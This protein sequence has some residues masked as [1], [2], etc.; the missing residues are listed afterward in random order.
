[1]TKKTAKILSVLTIIIMLCYVFMNFSEIFGTPVF[2]G[3]PIISTRLVITSKSATFCN[4]TLEPGWN[5]VSFP[6]LSDPLDID[7]MMS[8]LNNSYDSLR[9]YNPADSDD[10]WKSYNPDLPSW[11]RHDL[12][13][14]SRAR[15]YW[16][17]VEGNATEYYLNGNLSTP[18]LIDLED[19]WNLIGYPSRSI[20]KVNDTFG[21]LVPNFHY[22]HLY[23]ASETD[24][25]K[26]WTWNTTL[27]PSNQD[28]NY[29]LLYHGYW[30]YM[31]TT[32]TLVI[33]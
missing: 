14:I 8:P 16:I 6:C 11:V 27:Y 20:R 28:L 7:F 29:T 26:E 19:G 23:N 9:F 15:G 21:S 33:S 12:G 32:D 3:W 2:T 17:Y 5:L 25:W 24:K 22:V 4:M 10:P 31:S 18:T 1:M 30:I 13:E